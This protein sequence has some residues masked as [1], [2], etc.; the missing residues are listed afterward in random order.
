ML[1]EM[2]KYAE[3]ARFEG[4]DCEVAMLTFFVMKNLPIAT[5]KHAW[6][7]FWQGKHFTGKKL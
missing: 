2:K 7:M 5:N 1:E 4:I 3:R 6:D